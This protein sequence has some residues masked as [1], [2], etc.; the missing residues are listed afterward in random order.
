MGRKWIGESEVPRILQT[1][2]Y[3]T[4]HRHGNFFF[5]RQ[6]SLPVCDWPDWMT[7][8][9]WFG[10]IYKLTA[11]LTLE[12]IVKERGFSSFENTVTDELAHPTKNINSYEHV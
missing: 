6:R 9:E 10:G 5:E 2:L 3:L 8:F 1:N 12:N 7:H 11:K 4:N